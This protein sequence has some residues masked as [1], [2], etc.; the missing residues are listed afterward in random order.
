MQSGA[1]KMTPMDIVKIVYTVRAKN[2]E[3]VL[4]VDANSLFSH[5]Q[6]GKILNKRKHFDSPV[7]I[8][9]NNI[10]FWEIV[11]LSDVLTSKDS[12]ELKLCTLMH[13]LSKL[14]TL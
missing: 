6:L 2:F 7:I 14:L 1:A 11:K 9:I 10:S 3:P 8:R 12:H 5:L 4:L 13:T